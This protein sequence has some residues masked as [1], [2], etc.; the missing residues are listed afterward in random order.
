VGERREDNTE[1]MEAT[2]DNDEPVESVSDSVDPWGPKP[3]GDRSPAHWDAQLALKALLR[4][5]H[6]DEEAWTLAAQVWASW[7]RQFR[8]V[9]GPEE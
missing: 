3:Y 2:E 9:A 7:A 4:A 8:D 6:L 5:D 1:I